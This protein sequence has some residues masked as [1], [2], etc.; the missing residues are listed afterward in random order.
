MDKE[1]VKRCSLKGC[2]ARVI[3]KRGYFK[4]HKKGGYYLAVDVVTLNEGE[5]TKKSFQFCSASH[6]NRWLH[7]DFFEVRKD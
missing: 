7:N 3:P 1:E 4:T 2:N 5:H 6:L